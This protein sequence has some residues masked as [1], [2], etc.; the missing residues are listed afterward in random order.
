ML[1]NG[2][3]GTGKG[4]AARAIHSQSRRGQG[5]VRGG[6]LRRHSRNTCWKASSSAIMKGAFTDAKDDQTRPPGAGPRRDLV[7]RRDRRDQPAHADRSAARA[8]G[9]CLLSGRRHPAHRGGLPGHRG[10]QQRSLE[11]AIREGRFRED[12]FYRLNV[13]VLLPCLLYGSAR[14]TSRFWLEHF[15][16]RFAQEAHQAGRSD[17]PRGPG[18]DDA[19]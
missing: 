3:T 10:D 14:R 2:E 6:Q 16:H 7:S 5:P 12:L 19:L 17:Q 4:L 9:P 15:L 18:R 11:Q 1:I 8:G 13:D